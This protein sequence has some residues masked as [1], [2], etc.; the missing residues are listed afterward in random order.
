MKWSD[1][2]C[3]T[4]L[5][6]YVPLVTGQ[7]VSCPY[8]PTWV[9]HSITCYCEEDE[10]KRERLLKLDQ[11]KIGALHIFDNLTMAFY[12]IFVQKCWFVSVGTSNNPNNVLPFIQ[13]LWTTT[14]KIQFHVIFQWLFWVFDHW[15]NSLRPVFEKTFQLLEAHSK[16]I[17]YIVTTKEPTNV[18]I[19]GL[20]KSHPAKP[21]ARKPKNC[22]SSWVGTGL[23][24]IVEVLM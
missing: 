17:S 24:A 7:R 13:R 22:Y 9:R 6:Q 11:Q 15:S 23:G 2:W 10:P 8:V 14:K 18:A 20:M 21:L 1:V 5:P 19:V 16:T 12:V 4:W 3:G